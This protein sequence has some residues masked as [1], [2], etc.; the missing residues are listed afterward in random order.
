VAENVCP[1]RPEKNS[2]KQKIT[3]DPHPERNDIFRN[4]LAQG[5]Q[6]IEKVPAESN[7]QGDENYR[8]RVSDVFHSRQICY[9]LPTYTI[10]VK[11]TQ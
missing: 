6:Q 8:E 4:F 10:I 1:D 9:S 11:L 3:P 5:Q 2:L 7:Y